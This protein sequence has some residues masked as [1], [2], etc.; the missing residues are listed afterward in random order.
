MSTGFGHTTTC[1]KYINLDRIIKNMD[2]SDDRKKRIMD[3]LE[4]GHD[5]KYSFVKGD[6][7]VLCGG[8]KLTDK[9]INDDYEYG[10]V[11]H[12]LH[13]EPSIKEFYDIISQDRFALQRCQRRLE[14][15]EEQKKFEHNRKI[16]HLFALL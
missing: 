10:I 11:A 4:H 12:V 15:E 16:A 9:E 13:R 2:S 1:G 3:A 14:L 6:Q 7:I 8:A 5:I